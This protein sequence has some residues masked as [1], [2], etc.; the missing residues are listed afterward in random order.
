MKLRENYK[1]ALV[2]PTSMGVRICPPDGQPV[3]S[4]EMFRMQVTSAETNVASISSH[5]RFPG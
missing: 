3:Y 2:V 4:S 5:G 1:Y